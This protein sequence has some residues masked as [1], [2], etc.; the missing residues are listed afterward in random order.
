MIADDLRPV[1]RRLRRM[2]VVRGV[3]LVLIALLGGGLFLGGIDAMIRW[4]EALARYL[5]SAVWLSL[6]GGTLWY[7]LWR[8]WQRPLSDLDLARRIHRR[9][10]LLTPDLISGVEFAGQSLP[11]EA[12]SPTL[13][14]VVVSYARA[15]LATVPTQRLLDRGRVLRPILGLLTCLLF[16][17]GFGLWQPDRLAIGACRLT[18]PWAAWDWPR[19]TT[20]VYLD[21]DLRPLSTHQLRTPQG[22]NLTIYVEN[23]LGG[24]PDHVQFQR[25]T[26]SGAASDEGTLPQATL[27]DRQGHPHTVAVATW[28]MVEACEFRATGGDDDRTPWLKVSVVQPPKIESFTITVTPPAYTGLPAE[29]TESAVG[30]LQGLV[31]SQVDIVAHTNSP[32]QTAHL[33]RGQSAPVALPVDDSPRAISMEWTLQTEERDTYW[34][35]L[36][37][38]EGIASVRP[39]RY[40]IRGV[41]DEI[42]VVSL[43]EPNEDRRVTPRAIIDVRGS[44]RDDLGLQRVEL[45][46]DPPASGEIEPAARPPLVISLGPTSPGNHNHNVQYAW[47]LTGLQLQP[48]M[49]VRFWLQAADAYNLKDSTGQIGLS[50]ARVLS[51]VSP[52]DKRQELSERQIRLAN[53]L[54]ALRQKQ[55]HLE[56]TAREVRDQW[57]TVGSLRPEDRRDLERVETGQRELEQQLVDTQRGLIPELASI[58]HELETN[59]LETGEQAQQ[60]VRWEG[61]LQPLAQEVLPLIPQKLESVRQATATDRLQAS[62]REPITES[63]NQSLAAQQRTLQDLTQ[64][65]DELALWQ[66]EVNLT[67]RVAELTTRQAELRD[68]TTTLGQSTADQNYDQLTTQQLADLARSADRQSNLAQEADQLARQLLMT[69]EHAGLGQ[70]LEQQSI[71]TRMREIA[72]QLRKNHVQSAISAQGEL[73][74]SLQALQNELALTRPRQSAIDELRKTL[75]QTNEIRQRQAELHKRT[76]ALQTPSADSQ[77]AT[78]LDELQRLQ[79]ET[80]EQTTALVQRLRRQDPQAAAAVQRAE[81]RMQAAS[82]QLEN[83][84]IEP[85]T[86]EQQGA[87]DNLEQAADSLD[88][89]LE[90]AQQKA[91]EQALTVMSQLIT[92]LLERQR[93]ARDETI[94]LQEIRTTEG[95]WSRGQLKSLQQLAETQSELADHC[96]PLFTEST[97]LRVVQHCLQAIMTAQRSAARRLS[98]RDTGDAT[99]TDQRTA[100]TL[101]EQFLASAQPPSDEALSPMPPGENPPAESAPSD[102]ESASAMAIEVR[103]LLSM[104]EEI[105]RRTRELVDQHTKG[106]PLTVAQRQELEQLRLRQKELAASARDFLHEASQE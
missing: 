77:R 57:T 76:A 1:H 16:L 9:W 18:Q 52:D 15:Q 56:Q 26:A 106:Q 21:A 73:L 13:Q 40:E 27:R 104:Q 43:L 17:G 47:D 35:T 55:G 63:L 95:K 11:P 66:R 8:P 45:L 83:D 101:M 75:T 41:R 59:R 10:P 72:D 60:L 23:R 69:P 84:Q 88:K 50:A 46:I 102:T 20:L 3:G 85:A 49:T 34:L 94:R 80:R 2:L 14:S 93:G 19:R 44:A 28:S 78:E 97:S 32:L 71:A 36:M 81:E 74:E 70:K 37:D 99:Q 86:N 53:R 5:Q 65:S 48:G 100:E 89:E 82:E 61:I 79:R 62:A 105:Q 68:Q 6:L 7:S 25:I 24:L 54:D 22:E 58:R 103:L 31:G 91:E 87:L 30:H 39:Q 29:V 92:A 42:P 12:G 67:Q 51:I 98:E 33:H 90:H 4:R 96:E 38:R 64:L